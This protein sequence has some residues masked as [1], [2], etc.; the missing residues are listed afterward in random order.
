MTQ[1]LTGEPGLAPQGTSL[2]APDGTVPAS[3]VIQPISGLSLQ[4][5]A[6]AANLTISPLSE[7]ESV[8]TASSGG[9]SQSLCQLGQLEGGRPPAPGPTQGTLRCHFSLESPANKPSPKA[10]FLQCVHVDHNPRGTLRSC[11]PLLS[12]FGSLIFFHG[13]IRDD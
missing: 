5:T 4:P 6:A 1:Q 13:G 12:S 11:G 7:Q 3:V 2:Q 8:L 9:K 10:A